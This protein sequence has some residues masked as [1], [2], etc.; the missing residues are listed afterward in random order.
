[1]ANRVLAQHLEITAFLLLMRNVINWA[2]PGFS[3]NFLD[4]EGAT[5]NFGRTFAA[6]SCLTADS[7][8]RNSGLTGQPQ[9]SNVDIAQAHAV[10]T[11]AMKTI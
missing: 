11:A 10:G 2:G 3:D 4:L 6:T 5:P 7:R 1:M 8:Q 9:H